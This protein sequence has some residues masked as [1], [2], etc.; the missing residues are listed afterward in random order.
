MFFGF[1]CQYLNASIICII[2]VTIVE[3]NANAS[4]PLSN[5][6][7]K[8]MNIGMHNAIVFRVFIA[9]IVFSFET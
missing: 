9:F 7:N 4:S 2:P 3:S 6:A 8:E 1:S 5:I